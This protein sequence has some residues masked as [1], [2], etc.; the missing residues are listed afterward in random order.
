MGYQVRPSVTPDQVKRSVS[1]IAER[2]ACYPHYNIG[3]PGDELHE[4]FE[5]A[6]KAI[7]AL[8]QA[9]LTPICIIL[10]VFRSAVLH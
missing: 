5:S 3:V 4:P 9:L 2:L 1:S 8:I 7:I 6:N 10:Q